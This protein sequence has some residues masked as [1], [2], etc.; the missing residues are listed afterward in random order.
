MNTD[1]EK[2]QVF[3]WGKD[4]KSIGSGKDELYLHMIGKNN[5]IYRV[6]L[7]VSEYDIQEYKYG[8]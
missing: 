2:L 7:K 5:K 1:F 3:L 4:L 8:L 6:V